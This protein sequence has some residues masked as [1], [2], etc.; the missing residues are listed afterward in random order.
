MLRFLY[1]EV[2]SKP[3]TRIG[4]DSAHA[5]GENQGFQEKKIILPCKCCSCCFFQLQHLFNILASA[6]SELFGIH[7][8]LSELFGMRYLIFTI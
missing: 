7:A 4:T 2:G 8:D 3:E 6:Q 1:A 5:T